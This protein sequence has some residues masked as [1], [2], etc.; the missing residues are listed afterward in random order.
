MDRRSEPDGPPR[1]KG[2]TEKGR[3]VDFATGQGLQGLKADTLAKLATPEQTANTKQ[4][5]EGM[6]RFDQQAGAKKGPGSGSKTERMSTADI[7][8]KLAT[9]EQKKIDEQIESGIARFKQQAEAKKARSEAAP[10]D[11]SVPKEAAPKDTSVPKD[12]DEKTFKFDDW[13]NPDAYDKSGL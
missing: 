1:K 11:T 4:I 5:E 9:P 3:T 8:E 13:I 7:Q 12:D 6:K 2:R 10:K